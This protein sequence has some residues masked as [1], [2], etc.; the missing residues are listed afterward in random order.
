VPE[1]KPAWGG[2]VSARAKRPRGGTPRWDAADP[3][4]RLLTDLR[5]GKAAAL[6]QF[7][8]EAGIPMSNT[9]AIGDGANDLDMLEA[10]GLG[11]AFNA[12]P[13]VRAAADTSVSVPYLD[14]IVYLLGI[15]REE[16]EASDL[17]AGMT[18]PAPPL[19]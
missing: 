3:I 1:P 9:I 18:T 16:V 6:R 4:A 14:T 11:V 7:A 17:D 19:S 15:T 13:M 2:I 5:A 8:A 10:A 12:K